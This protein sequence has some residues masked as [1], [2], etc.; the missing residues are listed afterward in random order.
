MLISV[1]TF[2]VVFSLLVLVHEL[3]HAAAARACG[4]QVKEFGLGY[5]PRICVLARRGGTLYT[6]NA[7]P[8]GGFVKLRGEDDPH[9]AGGFAK[10]GLKARF[11][12]LVAGSLMNIALALALSFLCYWGGWPEPIKEAV[13]I[14]HVFPHSPAEAAGLREGDL[15]LTADGVEVKKPSDLTAYIKKGTPLTLTIKRGDEIL[16]VTIIPRREP[17]RGQGPLGILVVSQPVRMK[18]ER[19]PA[20]EAFI[21]GAADI[22]GIIALTLAAP[23][24]VLARLLPREVLRPVGPVGLA[25]LVSQA[26][27]ASL[28]TGWLFPL[29]RLTG[30]L[31]TSLAVTN[32]LPLPALDGGRILFLAAEALGKRI[33]PEREKAIHRLGLAFLVGVV[34]LTALY[35]LAHPVPQAFD[36]IKLLR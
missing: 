5:P 24:L 34:A 9:I 17:P 23:V 11:T 25:E 18:I 15:V 30:F 29:L 36:W 33:D 3:G 22:I 28:R 27:H 1:A 31:S 2:A 6:L 32:L 14:R 26:T 12:V 7:I 8:I 35:D 21:R 20:W 19:Y 13:A 16:S 4:I 10:A